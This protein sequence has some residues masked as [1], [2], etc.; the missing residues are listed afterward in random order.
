[1]EEV[2]DRQIAKSY[3]IEMASQNHFV[4]TDVALSLFNVAQ[5]GSGSS[6]YKE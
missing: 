1:M 6:V 5:L 4:F 2:E 3:F